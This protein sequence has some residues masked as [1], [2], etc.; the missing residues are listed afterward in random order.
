MS[1]SATVRVWL[2]MVL[3][4]WVVPFQTR[5]EWLGSLSENWVLQCTLSTESS[6][7]QHLPVVL[8][9]ARPWQEQ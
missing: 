9:A 1:S 6:V 8:E 2:W 4:A 5:T 7:K 3:Q